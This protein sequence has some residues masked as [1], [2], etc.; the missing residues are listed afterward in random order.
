[1]R[2]LREEREEATWRPGENAPGRGSGELR[3]SVAQ[4]SWVGQGS[5][6]EIT[7]F[8]VK[9]EKVPTRGLHLLRPTLHLETSLSLAAECNLGQA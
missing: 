3:G 4:V 2:D 5:R 6:K 1:M 8:G 9:G 7:M